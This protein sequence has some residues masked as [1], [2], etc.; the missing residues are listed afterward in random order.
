MLTVNNLKETRSGLLGEHA[1]HTIEET[2]NELGQGRRADFAHN[3]AS[4]L[5][6]TAGTHTKTSLAIGEILLVVKRLKL[7][8]DLGYNTFYEFLAASE[9]NISERMAQILMRAVEFI[10]ALDNVPELE[11]VPYAKADVSKIVSV[12]KPVREALSKKDFNGAKAW[13]RKALPVSMGG[14]SRS[15]LAK[16]LIEAGYSSKAPSQYLSISRR[17]GVSLVE[18]D[19]EEAVPGDL[20]VKVGKWVRGRETLEHAKAAQAG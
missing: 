12:V 2:L 4:Q 6:S 1:L 11:D 3:L 19:D 17:D 7:Y 10:Y 16:A 13:L 9:V 20:V 18:A 14:L 15:D 8:K 5:A